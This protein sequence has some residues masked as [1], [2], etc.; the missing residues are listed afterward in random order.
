MYMYMYQEC[1]RDKRQSLV[2][3]ANIIQARFDAE[4]EALSRKQAW[5]KANQGSVT[6]DSEA[7]YIAYCKEALFRIHILEQ[8][9]NM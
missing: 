7:D 9:L 2:E 8:R 4:T 5:Y 3:K 1:L 6:R